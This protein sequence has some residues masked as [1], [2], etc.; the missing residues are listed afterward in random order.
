MVPVRHVLPK[1]YLS[2]PFSEISNFNAVLE[3]SLGWLRSIRFFIFDIY[4]FQNNLSFHLLICPPGFILFC[5]DCLYQEYMK[6]IYL[7]CG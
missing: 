1:W 7:K 4:N 6:V 5:F 2:D 3:L